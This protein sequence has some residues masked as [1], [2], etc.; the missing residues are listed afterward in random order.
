MALEPVSKWVGVWS[1]VKPRWVLAGLCVSLA[2][3]LSAPSLQASGGGITVFEDSREVEFAQGLDFTL[4]IEGEEDI[5]EVTLLFRIVGNNSWSY[6]YPDFNPG[7]HVTASM[8]LLIGEPN[9]LP[10][11]IELEYYYVLVDA[12]GNVHETAP[13]VFEYLDERIQWDRTQ[14]G[15]LLL[16]HHGELRSSPTIIRQ[17]ETALGHIT[18]LLLLQ[19]PQPIRGVIYNSKAEAQGALPLQSQTI[20]EAHVFSGF[21]FPSNRVFVGIGFRTLIIVHEAAHLLLNQA[22]GPNALPMPAWLDEGFASYVQPHSTAYSGKSLSSRGLP[23]QAMT[24]VSGTPQ[25]IPTFYQKSESVVAYLIEEYGEE[26]FRRLVGE[27]AQGQTM[28]SALEETYGFG[29]SGLESRWS[30]DDRRPP[31]PAPGRT[32]GGSPWANFSTLVIGSLALAVLIA[33]AFR[34]AVSRL[35]PT[36]VPD[37]G[38]Q[39]WEDPDLWEFDERE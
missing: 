39:P 10:P 15:P 20:D 25:T 23:L 12:R 38:L 7:Q 4:T 21:A 17:V 26:S 11:G 8:S 33:V 37:E 28:E 14:I 18:D 22:V 19:S 34:Y 9:Y 16:I 30:T 29:I 24:R 6:A 27:L 13:N 31:A 32:R 35:R 5:V 36:S 1:R 2:L 3:W